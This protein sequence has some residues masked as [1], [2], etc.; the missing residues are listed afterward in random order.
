MAA[1]PTTRPSILLFTDTLET[2]NKVYLC[3]FVLLAA[4]LMKPKQI[5]KVLTVI[6]NSFNKE[7][8][9]IDVGSKNN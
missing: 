6:Q 2:I 8:P 9:N 4:S 3:A 1:A 5:Q 7:S